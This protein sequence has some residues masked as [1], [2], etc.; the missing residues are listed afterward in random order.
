MFRGVFRLCS[1][2]PGFRT[3]AGEADRYCQENNLI[4]VL[5]IE[6]HFKTAVISIETMFRRFVETHL[7]SSL[8]M[9]NR[10]VNE[11]NKNLAPVINQ[12]LSVRASLGSNSNTF[13]FSRKLS[14]K[15]AYYRSITSRI[16]S[17]LRELSKSF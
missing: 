12:A 4:L 8:F 7:Q 15:G 2:F 3:S 14:V 5:M 13:F 17:T 1:G 11:T 9:I 16:F 6:T 10:L